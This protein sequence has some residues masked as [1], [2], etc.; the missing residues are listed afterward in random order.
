MRNITNLRE[1]LSATVN[2]I[3]INVQN[4]VT[5][6]LEDELTKCV[7]LAPKVS[8]ELGQISESIL[9]TKLVVEQPQSLVVERKDTFR[10]DQLSES[11]VS[12]LLQSVEDEDVFAYAARAYN[13]GYRDV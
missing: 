2:G 6:S 8:V 4:M 11:L 12:S 1:E 5:E 3:A 13:V 10:K 7:E 9:S